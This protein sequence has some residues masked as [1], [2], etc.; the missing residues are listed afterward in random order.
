MLIG[1]YA[2][3]SEGHMLIGVRSISDWSKEYIADRSEGYMADRSDGTWL[4]EVRA[5]C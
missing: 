4:K 3:R 5:I 2:D 1:R